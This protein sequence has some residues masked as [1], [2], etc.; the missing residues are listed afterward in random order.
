MA[1]ET[2]REVEAVRPPERGMLPRVQREEALHHPIEALGRAAANLRLSA[3]STHRD[4]AHA[5]LACRI[6]RNVDALGREGTPPLPASFMR[7]LQASD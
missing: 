1:G 3:E 4:C 5:D 2:F 6:T 7:M